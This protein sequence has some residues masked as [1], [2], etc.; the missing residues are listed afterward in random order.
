MTEDEVVE[1]VVNII[2]SERPEADLTYIHDSVYYKI[3]YS[4]R[5][6]DDPKRKNKRSKTVFFLFDE[7]DIQDWADASQAQLAHMLDKLGL[8]IHDRFRTFDPSNDRPRSAEPPHEVWP[9]RVAS[10]R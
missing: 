8:H 2:R 6:H 10:L 4:E 5:T 9:V 7:A 1:S 3:R